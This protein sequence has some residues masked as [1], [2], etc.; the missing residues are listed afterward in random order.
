MKSVLLAT[1]LILTLVVGAG[2][3]NL[4][5]GNDTSSPATVYTSSGTFVQ[6][7]GQNAATGTAINAAGDIWTVAPSL[8]NNQVVEYNC[9]QTVLNSFVATV[10]GQWI[11]DMSHGW[12]NNLYAGT[13]E[14]WLFTLNDQTGAIL[15]SF[16][17]PNSSYTGV[18]F[19][20][21]NL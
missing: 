18:A 3:S 16:Q 6:F 8:G 15:S 9:S 21:T 17:V 14:G 13:F 11:E 5:I 10:N 1:L 4:Y 2:A 20:G 7:F 12:G 19:D